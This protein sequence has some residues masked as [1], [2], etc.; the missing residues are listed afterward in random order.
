[1]NFSM[2]TNLSVLCGVGVIIYPCPKLSEVL[3]VSVCSR[4]PSFF[5]VTR[6]KKSYFKDGISAKWRNVHF[7]VAR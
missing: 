6:A 2:V 5:A 7:S 4:G 1:M 3:L